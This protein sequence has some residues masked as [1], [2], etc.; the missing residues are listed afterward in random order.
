[1]PGLSDDC[2]VVSRQSWSRLTLITVITPVTTH[3]PPSAH[4]RTEQSVSTEDQIKPNNS[5]GDPGFSPANLTGSQEL[6]DPGTDS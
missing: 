5:A 6:P 1:M 4:R 3:L 2:H